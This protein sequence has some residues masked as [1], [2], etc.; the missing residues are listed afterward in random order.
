MRKSLFFTAV[1]LTVFASGTSF[2]ANSSDQSASSSAGVVQASQ[3]SIVDGTDFKEHAPVDC[4]AQN[5]RGDVFEAR[6]YILERVR[7]RVMDKCYAVSE[8]CHHTGCV[9]HAQ[10]GN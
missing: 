3:D 6:G 2:A 5:A 8:Y 4:Y 1:A 7:E 10:P 9:T